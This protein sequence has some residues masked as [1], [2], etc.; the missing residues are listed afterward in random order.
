VPIVLAIT[1]RRSCRLCS[2]LESAPLSA[3][4]MLVILASLPRAAI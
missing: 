1:A 4:L 2:R 3:A